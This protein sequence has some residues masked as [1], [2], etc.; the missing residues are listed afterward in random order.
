MSLKD[1]F[2]RLLKC[3]FKEIRVERLTVA[4]YCEEE[5]MPTVRQSVEASKQKILQL[6]GIIKEALT[7]IKPKEL[8]IP[9]IFLKE[10]TIG[11]EFQ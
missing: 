2:E 6:S 3:D 11:Q 4:N 10:S 9:D 7:I 5:S 1:C 8:N